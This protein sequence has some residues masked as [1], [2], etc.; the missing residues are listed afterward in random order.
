MGMVI[1]NNISALNTQRWLNTNNNAM[2]SSLEKLSSGYRINTASDDPSGLVISEKLR[3][4]N[5]GLERAV[6]NTNEA[7][8]VIGIA[9]GALTEINSILS[10]MRELALHAAN[11]GVTS[12]DQI[13]ADQAEMDSAIQTIDRIANT[14]KYSDEYLLN[15]NQSLTY[16]V[17]TT[18]DES[19][20]NALLDVG[21]T[22]VN[23]IY[24][25]DDYSINVSYTGSS[26]GT[27]DT[28]VCAQRAYFEAS[29]ATDSD[30][31]YDASTNL[32][33]ADQEFVLSGAEG[34]KSFSFTEGTSLGDVVNTIN[35]VSDST[36]VLATLVFDTT[37]TSSSSTATIA[38]TTNYDTNNSHATGE[39]LVYNF[40]SSGNILTASST[41][42]NGITATTVGTGLAAAIEVGENTDANGNLYV[43]WESAT[44]CTVYKDAEMT[45][46]VAEGTSTTTSIVLSELNDSGIGTGTA[47]L[48][49]TAGG[50]T[51]AGS[52][53]IISFGNA[54]QFDGEHDATGIEVEGLSTII[55]TNSAISGVDLGENT[56]ENGNIYVKVTVGTDKTS[57]TVSLYN[58]SSMSD[59]SL[60]ATSAVTNVSGDQSLTIYDEDTG[61]NATLNML[62]AGLSAN[63]EYTGTISFTDLGI[64]LY[65]EDYGSD[66]FVKVEVSEGALFLDSDEELLDAGDSGVEAVDYGQNAVISVNGQR[67]ELDGTSGTVSTSDI[68]ADLVFNEGELGA[69]TI[70]VA[71]YETGTL[72]SGI[73]SMSDTSNYATQAMSNTTET[74][75]NFE[76]GMQFQL[77]EGDSDSERTVYSIESVVAANLGLTSY[78]DDFDGDGTDEEMTLSVSDLLGGGY[79]ALDEDPV[80]ALTIID[81]AID[82]VTS[83]RARL[84]ATESNLLQ[85]N[86]N[87]LEVAIENITATESAIRDV[88]MATETTEYTKNQILVQSAT[89]MLAQANTIS[90]N[91]LQLLG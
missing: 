81:Q 53:S 66:A 67:I 12:S 84:G 45:M 61:L 3:A 51:T 47:T 59:D 88:D 8:N 6:E 85:T 58:D 13:E 10:T 79:A 11:D 30:T 70:A 46:A 49:L 26:N 82:D 23:Q 19:T 90:Q 28:A 75:D 78:T 35:S 43:K 29:V 24:K 18:V 7:M 42:T 73:G 38:Q 5:A 27:A 87:S 44:S 9:E 21:M 40:D 83:L 20:D 89:A 62:T 22:Q 71:G 16:D 68:N 55:G 60:L 76:G 31:E 33:T 63:S 72:A 4:Q 37:V 56:D 39:T 91:V 25:T 14:T 32:L 74:L 77:G 57:V 50:T 64:R 2:S 36:G 15:G 80:K 41:N 48:T 34:S 54:F 69:T 52:T 86:V 65:S 17:T 1:S